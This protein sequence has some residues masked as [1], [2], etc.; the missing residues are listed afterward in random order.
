[1]V[2][3]IFVIAVGIVALPAPGPGMLVLAFGAGLLAREFAAI[4]RFF[5]WLE[6][7]GWRMGGWGLNVWKGWSTGTR[8]LATGLTAVAAAG[9]LV[10]TYFWLFE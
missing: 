1:V 3:G 5:D 9:A 7:R 4:A 8:V 6:I 10:G 2:I